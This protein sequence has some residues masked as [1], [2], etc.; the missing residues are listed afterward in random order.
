MSVCTT[1][2]LLQ[3]DLFTGQEVIP[4]Q[5]AVPRK[6]ARKTAADKRRESRRKKQLQYSM[7]LPK[8]ETIRKIDF[9]KRLHE[10]SGNELDVFAFTNTGYGKFLINMLD[11]IPHEIAEL[12]AVGS[13]RISEIVAWVSRRWSEEPFSFEECCKAIGVDPDT[14]REQ[15]LETIQEL[16]SG[17]IDHYQVLRNNVID[18][19]AGVPAAVQWVLSESDSSMS[20]NDCCR[21]LGF[22]PRKARSEVIIPAE[23]LASLPE[24][25]EGET[26]DV[27]VIDVNQ[28]GFFNDPRAIEDLC[29]EPDE[30]A[31]A[32]T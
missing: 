9:K 23:I 28:L 17:R 10:Q 22:S 7:R 30:T 3:I 15:L 16:H 29:E 32:L 14:K 8:R 2:S 5:Y 19:E 18:A 13:N 27:R 26:T 25:E 12:V 20:F 4:G 11:Y 31:H 24:P 1:P 21:A 6:Y